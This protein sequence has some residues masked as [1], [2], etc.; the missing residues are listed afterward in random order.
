MASRFS[1]DAV[2]IEN[3][4]DNGL[5]SGACGY[6]SAAVSLVDMMHLSSRTHLPLTQIYGFLVLARQ[7]KVIKDLSR[8]DG[9]LH[10]QM[11]EMPSA[12]CG[13]Q[14]MPSTST[15]HADASSIS[16]P[17]HA[18]DVPDSRDTSLP[19]QQMQSG[20]QRPMAFTSMSSADVLSE[21]SRGSQVS[22]GPINN[23]GSSY[24]QPCRSG[25]TW[26]YKHIESYAPTLL[27]IN[28]NF[29]ANSGISM[30]FGKGVKKL[31]TLEATSEL[32]KTRE[33]K[34]R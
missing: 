31:R 1:R 20:V 13:Q 26:D 27:K 7:A 5:G 10:P 15:N 19:G 2:M 8:P 6:S 16:N 12:T 29:L 33:D 3:I 32:D 30:A 4:L 25:L 21:S 23:I 9:K 22:R 34:E 28:C 17:P 11:S 18:G 24:N 14:Q